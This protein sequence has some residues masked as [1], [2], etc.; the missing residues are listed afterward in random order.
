MP[1]I[2]ETK[3]SIFER[4]SVTLTA[5]TAQVERPGRPLEEGGLLWWNHSRINPGTVLD[6]PQPD[7]RYSGLRVSSGFIP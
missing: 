5:R 3:S 2:D 1:G 6:Q 7:G 4:R